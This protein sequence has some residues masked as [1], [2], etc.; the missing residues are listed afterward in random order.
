MWP[1]CGQVYS[2]Y[3]NRESLIFTLLK[4]R[5]NSAQ[6]FNFKR[7]MQEMLTWDVKRRLARQESD[8]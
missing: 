3:N 4:H 6:K 1:L 8:S 2:N 7:V 5:L